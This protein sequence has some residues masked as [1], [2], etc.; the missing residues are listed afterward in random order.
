MEP[1]YWGG[2]APPPQG[3]ARGLGTRLD[4]TMTWAKYIR[5]LQ[6]V[7]ISLLENVL[8]CKFVTQR[9]VDPLDR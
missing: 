7:T 2:Q 8:G 5:L 1:D 4:V 6:D 3:E 9:L